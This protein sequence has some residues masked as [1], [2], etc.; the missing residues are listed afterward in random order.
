MS[1]T[2]PSQPPSGYHQKADA[3]ATRRAQEFQK[4]QL[5]AQR[6]AKEAAEERERQRRAAEKGTA[7]HSN[8]MGWSGQRR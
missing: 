5:E 3:E 8:K 2:I 6:A 4:Q 7:D 1:G